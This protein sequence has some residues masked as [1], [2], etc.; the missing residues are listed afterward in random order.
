MQGCK[1]EQ[2]L[3]LFAVAG[4]IGQMFY[5]KIALDKAFL[6]CMS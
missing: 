6:F 2:Q 3:R 1:F 4:G 5:D